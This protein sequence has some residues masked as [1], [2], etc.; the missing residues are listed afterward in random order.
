MARKLP[1]YTYVELKDQYTGLWSSAKVRSSFKQAA[2]DAAKLILANQNKYETV[3]ALTKVPWIFI[4]VAHHLE[5]NCNFHTHLHN[6]DSLRARTVQE[7]PGRPKTGNPIFTFEES[8]CDAVTMF[9]HELDKVS[10]WVIEMFLYQW[11]RWNGWGYRWFHPNTLTAYL[12][13][14]TQHYAGGKYIRDK[15]WSDTAVS[16]QIG[17]VAILKS[18]LEIDPGLFEVIEDYANGDLPPPTPE[19]VPLPGPSQ[20][21]AD[22]FPKAHEDAPPSW[23]REKWKHLLGVL[24]LGGTAGAEAVHPQLP[25]A[26]QFFSVTQT[27]GPQVKTILANGLV[28][29]ALIVGVTYLII[30]HVLP[31]LFGGSS[32]ADS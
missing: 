2:L 25:S 8:A 6:G 5:S 31:S 18:L 11:E 7:P 12:W 23:W 10:G 30:G 32:N 28:W 20:T 16:D 26:D 19:A 1:N 13:S 22:S 9:P 29:P 27:Y 17:C 21:Q 3:A 14:G 15:V 24:G 4:G